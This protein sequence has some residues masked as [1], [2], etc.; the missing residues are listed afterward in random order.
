MSQERLTERG[1][2][3]VGPGPLCRGDLAEVLAVLEDQFARFRGT[4]PCWSRYWS[5]PYRGLGRDQDAGALAARFAAAQPEPT[6]SWGR[7]FVP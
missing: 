6:S 4:G 5:R 7:G 1:S 3:T 2:S